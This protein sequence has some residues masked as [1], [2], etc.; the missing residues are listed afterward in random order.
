V[1][2]VVVVKAMSAKPGIIGWEIVTTENSIE[3]SK[4]HW[5][6][7]I[8]DFRVVGMHYSIENK[9]NKKYSFSCDDYSAILRDKASYFMA[10]AHEKK[11][12]TY[13]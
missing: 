10:T 12:G 2:K 1:A 5:F 3:E 6:L 8:S 13:S 7:S 9:G 4:V 11:E